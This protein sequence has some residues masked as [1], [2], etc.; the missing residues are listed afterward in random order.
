MGNKLKYIRE[1]NLIL[2]KRYLSE[3]GTPPTT[4]TTTGATSG[5]S[6]TQ[7]TTLKPTTPQIA[8]TPTLS[9]EQ[10]TELEKVKKMSPTELPSKYMKCGSSAEDIVFDFGENKPKIH[11]L[12]NTF[13]IG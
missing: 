4:G 3:Q 13:C 11:K 10:K 8:Q 6:T 1:A 9:P 7:T 5:V 2:E 12:K